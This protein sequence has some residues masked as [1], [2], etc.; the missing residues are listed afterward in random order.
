MPPGHVYRGEG[1]RENPDGP[2][3]SS[4]RVAQCAVGEDAK[5][6]SLDE[7]ASSGA[8]ALARGVV[9]IGVGNPK[10]HWWSASAGC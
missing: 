8:G 1:Q 9:R 7:D 6:R 3:E 5:E 4:V 2:A 10:R